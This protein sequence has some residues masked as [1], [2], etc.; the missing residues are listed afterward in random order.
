MLSKILAS[1][2]DVF[3]DTLPII[4]ISLLGIFG[5][6][7]VIILIVKLLNKFSDFLEKRKESTEE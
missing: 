5:T 6:T 7:A 1:N 4:G 3:V 2:L